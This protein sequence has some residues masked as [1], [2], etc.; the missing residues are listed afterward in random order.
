MFI[1]H[2]AICVMYMYIAKYYVYAYYV[3]VYV[4]TEK[5]NLYP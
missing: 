2:V 3:Y 5:H 1:K 4:L